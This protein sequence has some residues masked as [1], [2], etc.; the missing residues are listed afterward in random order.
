[1]VSVRVTIA[2][3]A[4]DIDNDDGYNPEV[5]D[6]MCKHA[7]RTCYATHMWVAGHSQPKP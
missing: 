6:D 3:I 2:D 4:V 7:A 5:V 1:M